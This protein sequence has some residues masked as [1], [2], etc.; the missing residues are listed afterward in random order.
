MDIV[1]Y[2]TFTQHLTKGEIS[3]VTFYYFTSEIEVVYTHEGIEYGAK[4]PYGPYNDDLLHTVLDEKNI[5]YTILESEYSDGAAF[6]SSSIGTIGGFAFMIVP[7]I[8]ICVIFIQARTIRKLTERIP[9]P[10]D[11]PVKNQA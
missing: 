4:G 5:D 6:S 1:D 7:L 8:M 11:Y 10:V 9:K 3:D 2:K